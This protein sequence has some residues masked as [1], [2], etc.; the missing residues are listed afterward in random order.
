MVKVSVIVPIYNVQCYLRECLKS[1]LGQTLQE[2]EVIC[3]N[4]GSTDNSLEIMKEYAR[5]DSRVKILNKENT[6][7]GASMNQGI[8][9]SSGE[10]IGIVEPDDYVD[11]E[12]YEDLYREADGS[13]LD[14]VKG[15]FHVFKGSGEGK[16]SAVV[17][18]SLPGKQGIYHKILD[19]Q[20]Y[21]ELIIYDDYHW[22]GIYRKSF[23]YRNRIMF[24][25]TPGAAYQ[26]NGFKY[27]TICMAERVMYLEKAYYWYRRDNL[28]ASSY[29][30]RGL[31]LMHGEYRFIRNFMDRNPDRVKVFWA[32]Y[33]RKFYYQFQDQ[34]EKLLCREWE[35]VQPG[36]ALDRYRPDIRLGIEEGYLSENRMGEGTYY[37]LKFLLR[38]PRAY[39]EQ[40]KFW[41]EIQKE[42][43]RAW[44]DTLKR[45]E[46]I[47]VVCGGVKARLVLNFADFNQLTN[48]AAVC[49]NSGEKWGQALYGFKIVPTAQAAKDYPD[50]YYLIAKNGDIEDVRQQLLGLG[51]PE[52]KIG[53]IGIR[54]NSF[55][56]LESLA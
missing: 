10:Y 30:I 18:V 22:K 45:Q 26:D 37:S 47:I 5:L 52:E 3:I 34:L 49:D 16:R 23:L 21:P 32:S 25:E 40:K 31:E 12:M 20:E 43:D 36:E 44:L 33:Y 29:N 46:E 15:N 48:I 38:Y 39:F 1:I 17:K 50:G 28:S 8:K 24:H 4:D 56:S 53:T 7:Y 11:P 41:G 2:I 6:G 27:Q 14:W 54:L 51:I 42:K 19:P 35:E 13:E 55:N 9:M